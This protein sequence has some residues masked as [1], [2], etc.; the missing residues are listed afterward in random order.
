MS[1]IRP[2]AGKGDVEIFNAVRSA[3]SPQFQIRIP[4]A[5]QGNIRNAVDT[6]RNFPYL[7]DE[8]TGVLIQRLIGL[9]VQHADW[10]D[11]LKLI[12]SPR[13]LK[14]YGSTYEQ[15]AVGLVKARTRNFNQEYLGDDVYGRYNVPTASAFHP[16]TFDHYGGCAADRFRWRIRHVG[17]HCGDHERSDPQ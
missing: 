1:N 3:T 11:P 13:T 9:Y 6:L 7:R 2:L 5:T 17:L 14:R 12:G 8:F 16:L 15:A 4:S 10:D